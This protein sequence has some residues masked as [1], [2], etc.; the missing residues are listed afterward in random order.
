MPTQSRRSRKRAMRTARWQLGVCFP[1]G[2]VCA[3]TPERVSGQVMRR[4]MSPRCPEPYAVSAAMQP[5]WPGASERGAARRAGRVSLPPF[6]PIPRRSAVPSAGNNPGSLGRSGCF[7][8]S[9]RRDRAPLFTWRRLVRPVLPRTSLQGP[10]R[11]TA[12]RRFLPRGRI[13][14]P[15]TRIRSTRMRLRCAPPSPHFLFTPS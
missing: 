3:L 11:S 9:T 6:G 15:E 5:A 2:S 7:S 1:V 14:S 12:H 4:S 13:R 8:L 10:C